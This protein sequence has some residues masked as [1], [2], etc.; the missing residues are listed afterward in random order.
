MCPARE[1]ERQVSKGKSDAGRL[2]A[3][4]RHAVI[5]PLIAVA[6]ERGQLR[7]EIER[8]AAKVWRHPLG[9][10]PVQFAYS[11]IERW[12]YQARS[13]PIDPLAGLARRRRSDA[14]V[15][16]VITA[17]LAVLIERQY[18]QHPGWTVQLHVDNL[19]VEVENGPGSTP[20]SEAGSSTP[21]TAAAPMPS[22]STIRRHM[23]RHGFH[24]V[25]VARGV[26]TE[27]A[28]RARQRYRECEV[29]SY[30]AEQVHALWH[31]DYHQ[32]SR[33]VATPAGAM[34]KPHLL[35]IIDDHSRLICHAQW[36]WSESTET[37]VHGLSQAFQKRALPRALMTDNGAAMRGEELVSGL[38]EL[39]IEHAHTLAYSAY[40]NGKIEVF[41]AQ[42]EGRLIAMLEGLPELSIEL[43]N[44]YTLAWVEQEYQRT[45]HEEIDSAPI[46]RY[47]GAPNVGR[48]SP[49]AEQ[50]RQRMRRHK[51]PRLRRSDGTITIERRR[52]EIP[53]AYHH[54]EVIP[55]RYARWDLSYVHIYDHRERKPTRRIFPLD[56]HANADGR[57][58]QRNVALPATHGEILDPDTP[59]AVAPLLERYRRQYRQSGLPPALLPFHTTTRP[60]R[61]KGGKKS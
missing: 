47:L 3:E 23:R 27:G 8:L 33:A 15:S 16:R 32:C 55:V 40:Q 14:G 38:G 52:F 25:R 20:G 30:E 6:I 22:Y 5:G 21:A 61:H 51:S 56:R 50:L 42:L 57:R 53:S 41:W 7:G 28:R 18:R 11:T 31:L 59:G 29:R 2:W 34:E 60:G 1:E 19:A 44:E 58:G 35:A 13:E 43:L 46:E 24:R 4:F 17:E 54:L 12:Y 36:Y 45:G 37:L 49:D 48:E 10:A 26:A 39:D 9:G